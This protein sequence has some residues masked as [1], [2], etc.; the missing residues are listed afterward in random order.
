MRI[1]VHESKLLWPATDPYPPD[2]LLS[3]GTGSNPSGAGS[4]PTAK[5]GSGRSTSK[6]QGK[7]PTPSDGSGSAEGATKRW[8]G[9]RLIETLLRRVDSIL[10]CDRAWNSFL[11]EVVG[12]NRSEELNRRYQRLDLDLRRDPPRLDEKDK[13]ELLRSI[14][15]ERLK[16]TAEMQKI[17]LVTR[18]LVASCFYF[19]KSTIPAIQTD[20]SYHVLGAC[21]IKFRWTHQLSVTWRLRSSLTIFGTLRLYPLPLSRRL[22]RAP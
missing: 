17:K 21:Y 7:Q 2:I 15:R 6:A 3:I 5:S 14:V 22:Q 13:L 10:D 20:D 12:S 19:D 9:P 8:R 16:E 4:N 11:A 1:A 18:Q